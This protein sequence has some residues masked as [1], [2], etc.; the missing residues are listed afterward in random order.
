MRVTNSQHPTISVHVASHKHL[1]LPTNRPYKALFVGAAHH[2]TENRVSDWNYDDSYPGNISEKNKTFCELTGLHWIWHNDKSDITG[3]VHYRRFLRL[4]EESELPLS[5]YEILHLLSQYDCI[6]AQRTTCTSAHDGRICSVA[7]QYRTC[8]CSTDLVLTDAV[9]K[10]HFREYHPAFRKILGGDSLYP[11]N[12]LICTKT[13]F[14]QYCKWLFSV[15]SRLEECINPYEDRDIYQQRVFGFIAERLLNTY[16]EAKKLSV[17]ECPVFNPSDIEGP[18]HTPQKALRPRIILDLSTPIIPPIQNGRD[19]SSVFDYRFYLNHNSDLME[20]PDLNQA[21]ALWH[22]LEHGINEKRMAHPHFSIASYMT[23]HPE[24]KAKFN[25]DPKLYLEH[26]L[27]NPS[28]NSHVVGY[29][30]RL[31]PIVR[32]GE[33]AHSP[34][35]RTCQGK[36]I[37]ISVIKRKTK[38]AEKQ[39]VID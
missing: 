25:D 32:Q 19:Y 2:Q 4:N 36:R 1:E 13:I 5:E 33:N 27:N 16:I 8:H 24:L 11:C 30:N 3:L 29:E 7:E 6:V 37:R 22:F 21:T 15:E 9:I 35:A 18:K 26:F 31:S 39:P 17:I 12:I 14:D 38:N 10:Q 20:N 28:D 34:D 23:G